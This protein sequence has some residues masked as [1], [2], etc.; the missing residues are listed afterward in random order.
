[1]EKVNYEIVKKA[2]DEG[3]SALK[4]LIEE[5]PPEQR[6]A[7]LA[8]MGIVGVSAMAI[9]KLSDIVMKK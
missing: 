6:N 7:A 9:K 5:I 8:I 3:F 1:M 4:N 2:A